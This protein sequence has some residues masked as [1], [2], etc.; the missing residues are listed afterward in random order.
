MKKSILRIS[1]C[2]LA[3]VTLVAVSKND[4]NTKKSELTENF[5]VGNPG[6][7][8]INALS[9]GP[10]GI[11][12]IGDSKNA[13][14]YALDTKDN[15]A[16]TSSERLVV[17]DVDNKIAASLGTTSNKIRVTD[18]AVN[19]KSRSVYFSVNVADGTPVVL[20]LNGDTFENVNL[21]EASYS[22]IDIE[23]AISVDKKDR[24]GRSQRAL[25]ISDLK[26]H[27]GKVMVTGLS[28]KE[29]SSTFR[30]INFPFDDTQDHA[31]LE[32]YHAAHG[33]YETYAPIRTFNVVNVDNKDYLMASYTCTPLVLFPMNELKGGTHVKGRTIAEL[34]AGNS[35]LD[36][37]TF[38]RDGKPYF[39]MANTNRPVM[40]IDYDAIKSFKSELTEPVKGYKAEGLA[41]TS[42]P[43]VNVLQLDNLDTKNVVYL[44]RTSGGELV[45]VSRPTNRI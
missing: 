19:P 22:K 5:I 16:I 25:A 21:K 32:I 10:E 20:K 36:M 31:S 39:L 18:M 35:P 27:N 8:S 29:F 42:L 6:I 34:G 37:I 1:I 17:R 12:F 44:Q 4:S 9:F 43:M 2:A 23:N 24:R 41:F 28:N 15:S 33:K 40:R 13:A 38:E 11:L 45:L 7:S 3:F 14:I 30:S 26:Y